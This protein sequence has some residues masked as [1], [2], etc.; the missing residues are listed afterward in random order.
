M[1]KENGEIR[2]GCYVCH[3]GVN[4]AAMVD[5]KALA[6]YAASMPECGDIAGLQI[7]VFGS[8][9]GIDSAGYPRT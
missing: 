4:I 2:I 1:A 3:C 5:V 7:Y 8:G 6:E 9:T